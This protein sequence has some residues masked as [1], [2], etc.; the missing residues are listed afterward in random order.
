MDI[1]YFYMLFNL[2]SIGN[3][4]GIMVRNKYGKNVL[5]LLSLKFLT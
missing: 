2:K 4:K 1:S 3:N 5:N